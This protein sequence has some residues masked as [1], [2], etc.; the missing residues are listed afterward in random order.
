MDYRRIKRF[1]ILIVSDDEK[2]IVPLK[3]GQT[4]IQYYVTNEELFDILS[5]THIRTGHG[6][7]TRMLKVLQITYKN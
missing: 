4:N 1:D 2:L 3:P 6:G 7:R 5:E